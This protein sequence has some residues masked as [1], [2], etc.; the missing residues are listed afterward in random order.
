MG[1]TQGSLEPREVTVSPP[2]K[3]DPSLPLVS[4][5]LLARVRKMRHLGPAG[6]PRRHAGSSACPARDAGPSERCLSA[7]RNPAGA[8]TVVISTISTTAEKRF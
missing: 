7:Q 6:P 1:A 3:P 2:T 4:H 5:V 8:T